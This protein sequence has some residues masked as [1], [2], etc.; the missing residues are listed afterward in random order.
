MSPPL[1]V[2]Q[3]PTPLRGQPTPNQNRKPKTKR[4]GRRTPGPSHPLPNSQPPT[5]THPKHLAMPPLTCVVTPLALVPINPLL[6]TRLN[7]LTQ[8]LSTEPMTL[9]ATL[10]IR[11]FLP[12]R[13]LPLTNYLCMNLP[14]SRPRGLFPVKCL[15]QF[16]KQKQWS[17]LGARTLLTR[18]TAL[19]RPLNLHPALIRTSLCLVV[20][21]ALC[22]NR[23]NAHPLNTLH[24][25][26]AVR[27][28]PRTLLPETLL[29]RRFTLVP[30]AGATTGLGNPR[31]LPTF[32]GSRI[33]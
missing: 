33:L 7:S 27:F 32:L 16:L 12:F 31:P 30:A 17:E 6:A 15:L 5:P 14:E 23:V 4:R 25:L 19:P 26:G 13:K 11:R 9:G 28:R 3:G 1:L 20:T 10:G 2:P 29:L 8:C 21:L 22:P 18:Q 24:L